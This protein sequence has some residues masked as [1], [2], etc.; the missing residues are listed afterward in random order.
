[1]ARLDPESVKKPMAPVQVQELLESIRNEMEPIASQ[2]CIAIDVDAQPIEYNGLLG[3]LH[4]MVTNLVDNAI[5][6]T[7]EGGCILLSARKADHFLELSVADNGPGIPE[8]DRQQVFKRFYRALGTHVPG[9]GLGL[10]IV[11]R[12]AE[13]H[14]GSVHVE[15][16]L[17]GRGTSMVVKLPH[18][19]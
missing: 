8:K 16:G 11:S 12:I 14:G 3:A 7:P 5:K 6:Y 18:A 15:N 13:I 17:D 1:M 4:L 9:N 10:A 19:A 2:K